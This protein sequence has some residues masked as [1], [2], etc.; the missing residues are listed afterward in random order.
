MLK[1]R[2]AQARCLMRKATVDVGPSSLGGQFGSDAE[3]ASK[4]RKGV[5]SLWKHGLVVFGSENP[6]AH[7]KEERKGRE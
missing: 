1:G 2:E 7:A 5:V 4:C 3:V 6:R